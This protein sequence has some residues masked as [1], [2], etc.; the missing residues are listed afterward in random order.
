M[1]KPMLFLMSVLLL[2]AASSL[3]AESTDYISFVNIEAN[4][5]HLLILGDVVDMGSGAVVD[6]NTGILLW[7]IGARVQY[8]NDFSLAGEAGV[9]FVFYAVYDTNAP[10]TQIIPIRT[11][12]VGNVRYTEY[13]RIEGTCPA[14]WLHVV[15]AGVK[16]QY[17]NTS[18]YDWE[19]TFA[20]LIFYGGYRL[21]SYYAEFAPVQEVELTLHALVGVTARS[22][23][24]GGSTTADNGRAVFGVEIGAKWQFFHIDIAYYDEFFYMDYALRIPITIM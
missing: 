1:K 10:Y 4:P 24:S 11:W 3:H 9:G 8:L 17:I 21:A 19:N 22:Y 12:E 23:T 7:H 16:P 18:G 2:A 13:Q 5:I 6:F 14:A 20:D 15:E